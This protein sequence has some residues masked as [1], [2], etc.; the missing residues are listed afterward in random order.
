MYIYNIYII[1]TYI[2][3]YLW[4][5]VCVCLYVCVCVCLYVCVCVC[6]WLTLINM[7]CK[8]FLTCTFKIEFCN[9]K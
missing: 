5:C 8:Y 3:I 7:Q 6:V 9:T 1:N 4:V 2:Y